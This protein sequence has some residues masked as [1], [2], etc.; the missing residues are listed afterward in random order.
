[1]LLISTSD[2][3]GIKQL[4]VYMMVM[5]TAKSEMYPLTK[6]GKKFSFLKL[7][8]LMD[9]KKVIRQRRTLIRKTFGL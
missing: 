5:R 4:N 1:M 7:F 8:S 2:R 6:A 3:Y 9:K